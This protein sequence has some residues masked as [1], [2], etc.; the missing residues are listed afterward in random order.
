M[1][2]KQPIASAAAASA[3]PVAPTQATTVP[4]TARQ[5]LASS[6]VAP[7]PPTSDSSSKPPS[8]PV[9]STEA[10]AKG[11][12]EQ[13]TTSIPWADAFHF[14]GP[15]EL[16]ANQPP[17]FVPFV[18]PPPVAEASAASAAALQ[19]SISAQQTSIA[20]LIASRQLINA[21]SALSTA[22]QPLTPAPVAQPPVPSSAG[23]TAGPQPP[24][25]PPVVYGANH[26]WTDESEDEAE[27][28]RKERTARRPTVQREGNRREQPRDERDTNSPHVN[29]LGE[30][31]PLPPNGPPAAPKQPGVY[32]SR[33]HGL[34]KPTAQQLM[35]QQLAALS[36]L[37]QQLTTLSTLQQQQRSL[38]QAPPLPFLPPSMSAAQLPGSSTPFSNDFAF[39]PQPMR[40]MPPSPRMGGPAGGNHSWP[41]M[42]V[43]QSGR[44]GPFFPKIRAMWTEEDR[45]QQ[46][47]ASTARPAQKTKETVSA[48]PLLPTRR[49]RL[50]RTKKTA[51]QKR[52]RAKKPPTAQPVEQKKTNVEETVVRAYAQSDLLFERHQQLRNEL[53]QQAEESTTGRTAQ[54]AVQETNEAPV[55]PLTNEQKQRSQTDALTAR[56]EQKP[57]ESEGT[58]ARLK[59]GQDFL[60]HVQL[61]TSQLQQRADEDGPAEGS[62]PDLRAKIQQQLERFLSQQPAVEVVACWVENPDGTTVPIAPAAPPA[63]VEEEPRPSTSKEP[64]SPAYSIVNLLDSEDETG[65]TDAEDVEVIDSDY[66]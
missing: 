10:A 17:P 64:E 50:Q 31:L 4:L 40:P 60:M 37:Q 13:T 59:R 53:Q 27:I 33:G 57:K 18:F 26:L 36:T 43:S 52:Q 11:P 65:W 14:G 9:P 48:A 45:R 49:P 21:T 34:P 58:V 38:T 12:R 3:P 51:E 61:P 16:T 44:P 24:K 29:L 39:N 35:A 66:H 55:Q 1:V 19:A 2:A 15:A 56:P 42:P 5:P 54:P 8:A 22:E 41:G 6:N 32:S 46:A 28:Q 63:A 23:A 62:S 25:R 30:P 7:S 20:A 47:A